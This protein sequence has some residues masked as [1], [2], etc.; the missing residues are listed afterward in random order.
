MKRDR[1]ESAGFCRTVRAGEGRSHKRR[2]EAEHGGLIP[3]AYRLCPA[4]G[5][6]VPLD[7]MERYCINDGVRMVECCPLCGAAIGS[8]YARYCACCGLALRTSA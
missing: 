3:L 7:S 6:A 2:R 5:R 1:V 4:C 8:P